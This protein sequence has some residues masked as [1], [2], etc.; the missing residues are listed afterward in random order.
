MLKLLLSHDRHVLRREYIAR[1]LNVYFIITIVMSGVMAALLYIP[2]LF[3]GVQDEIISAELAN[4][5]IADGSKQRTEFEQLSRHIQF[6]YNLFA[7]PIIRPFDV[8]SQLTNVASDGIQ[9]T[10]VNILKTIANEETGDIVL[11][12]TLDGRAR[13]RSTLVAY[14]KNLEADDMFDQVSVPPTNFTKDS[15][16]D[17]TISM[18][19]TPLPKNI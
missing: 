7:A 16:I 2:H 10:S 15:D 5:K 3:V 9:L 4:A 18:T 1:L 8:M 14:S 13:D 17:F 6:E 19:T 11:T 12:I